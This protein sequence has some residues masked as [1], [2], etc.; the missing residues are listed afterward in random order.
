MSYVNNKIGS[1]SHLHGMLTTLSHPVREKPFVRTI[2]IS[3]LA[4]RCKVMGSS[5]KKGFQYICW[6]CDPD[7]LPLPILLLKQKYIDTEFLKESV[8]RYLFFRVTEY[9]KNRTPMT[10]DEDDDDGENSLR[11]PPHNTAV[12][13][14]PANS[15]TQVMQM[16]Q[17]MMRENRE[18]Q[19]LQREER[20]EERQR[21]EAERR[22]ERREERQRAE[23]ERREERQQAEAERREDRRRQAEQFNALA[24]RPP[25]L[26]PD[27]GPK[28]KTA[29][30]SLPA[31]KIP[32]FSGKLTEWQSFWSSFSNIVDKAEGYDDSQKLQ[33]LKNYLDGEAKVQIDGYSFDHKRKL[34][35]GQRSPDG[36]LWG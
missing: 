12:L 3:F 31:L 24:S 10:S 11:N 20:R 9:L 36:Y 32:T 30:N 15:E 17:M 29:M 14:K 1:L 7:I 13:P 6:E 19:H 22:E 2:I 26:I 27:L 8:P 18:E 35:K 5:K 4:F 21:A 25:P 34:P 28:T 16:M 23:A 33:Y